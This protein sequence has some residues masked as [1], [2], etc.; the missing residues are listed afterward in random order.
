MHFSK[1]QLFY[2]AFRSIGFQLSSSHILQLHSF[3]FILIDLC[4]SC[5]I[6]LHKINF[7]QTINIY[8]IFGKVGNFFVFMERKNISTKNHFNRKRFQS[9]TIPIVCLLSKDVRL[10][11]N[12]QKSMSKMKST[13]FEFQIFTNEFWFIHVMRKTRQK[14]HNHFSY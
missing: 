11:Q 12:Q 6:Y 7:N 8:D 9:K 13:H 4:V 10:P 3:H 5:W 2:H 14:I 1:S